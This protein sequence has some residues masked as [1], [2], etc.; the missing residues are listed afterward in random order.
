MTALTL[1]ADPATASVAVQITGAPAGPVRI[2]RTDTNGTGTVRQ[3]AGQAPI[4]GSL[5][6]VD[7]EVAL[8]GTA[9]YDVVDAAAVSTSATIDLG[10]A[11]GYDPAT[12]RAVLAPAQYP[13][14]GVWVDLILDYTANRTAQ[15]T[16]HEVVGR[17]DPVPTMGP[18]S[19][20]TGTWSL[21]CRDAASARAVVDAA[22]L[23]LVLLL[24]QCQHDWMDTYF[25]ASSTRTR[26]AEVTAPRRWLMDLDYVEVAAP[27][28]DLLTASPL[29]SYADLA[30]D[31]ATYD[32]ARSA[33]RNYTDLV[34]NHPAGP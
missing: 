10:T 32:A 16:L 8:T 25:T 9:R 19:T 11:F 18:L 17:S 23:G 14:L 3:Y 34:L 15:T 26:W 13:A 21:W 12:T 22:G 5:A 20:R 4:S 7:Y 2:T 1:T 31:Y 24:R 29:W 28:G 33:F 6:V 27:A 30:D